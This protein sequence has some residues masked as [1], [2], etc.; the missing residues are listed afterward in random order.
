MPDRT[1]KSLLSRSQLSVFLATCLLTLSTTNNA[2]AD[3]MFSVEIMA[4]G[5]LLNGATLTAEAPGDFTWETLTGQSNPDR[6][7]GLVNDRFT[8][9]IS[10]ATGSGSVFNGTYTSGAN[11]GPVF[12]PSGF[13][14]FVR[15]N[16]SGVTRAANWSGGGNTFTWFMTFSD[17]PSQPAPGDPIAFDLDLLTG[18]QLVSNTGAFAPIT[19]TS[20]VVARAVATSSA[21]PEPSSFLILSLTGF[22]TLA[23]RRTRMRPKPQRLDRFA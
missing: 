2:F 7:Y 6:R 4:P 1:S 14:Q 18:I 20:L 5:N 11:V 22:A 10:G 21:V 8:T 13:I 3:L 17:A 16:N 15:F 23:I 9:T 12:L 19:D